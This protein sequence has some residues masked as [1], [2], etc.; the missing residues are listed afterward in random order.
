MDMP[1]GWQMN[2]SSLSP[3][4]QVAAKCSVGDAHSGVQAVPVGGD[5]GPVV[6]PNP[7][8]AAIG[9]V[10][11]IQ[12]PLGVE[13]GA[14]EERV[15]GRAAT[16]GIRPFRALKTPEMVGQAGE[17]ASGDFP[18]RIEEHGVRVGEAPGHGKGHVPKTVGWL[19]HATKPTPITGM[20]FVNVSEPG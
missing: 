8:D 4:I 16:I 12:P 13:G 9:D 14:F 20:G 17:Q 6:V 1:V 2:S 5:L 19:P 18:G 10:G 3:P 7:E 15:D 11:D